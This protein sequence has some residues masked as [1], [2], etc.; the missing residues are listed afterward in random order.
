[1]TYSVSEVLLFTCL[2]SITE[3]TYLVHSPSGKNTPPEI[4]NEVLHL[5]NSD[6]TRAWNRQE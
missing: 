5:R 3:A 6:H 4:V 1:M 2:S